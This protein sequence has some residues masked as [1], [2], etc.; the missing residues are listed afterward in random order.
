MALR[1]NILIAALLL[2]ATVTPASAMSPEYLKSLEMKADQ[3][4]AYYARNC[5][6]HVVARDCS[7]VA[8]YIHEVRQQ[9]GQTNQA[10]QRSVQGRAFERSIESSGTSSLHSEY[11]DKVIKLIKL[12]DRID[13]ILQQGVPADDSR[14]RE[15]Q[16]E[17][18]VLHMRLLRL[19]SRM[20]GAS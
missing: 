9:I 6:G 19:Q 15:L 11:N 18:S 14:L 10:L 7:R 5:T 2:M 4:T 20:K 13:R 17:A 1:K 16:S 12:N 3:L 8:G